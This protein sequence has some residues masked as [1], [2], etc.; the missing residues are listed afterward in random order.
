[1]D[2]RQ[3]KSD[4]FRRQAAACL[5][6][7]QR[8]SLHEDRVRMMEMAQR[9]LDLAQQAEVGE[10]AQASGQRQQRG[11]QPPPPQ[12]EHGHQPVLQQQQ[13]QPEEDD[14]DA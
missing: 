8:M 11:N 4:D 7:A 1:M 10:E 2:N 3:A 12:P 6:V 9:W 5:E 14:G 13:V